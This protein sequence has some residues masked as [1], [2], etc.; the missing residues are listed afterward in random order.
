MATNVAFG[1]SLSAKT[2]PDI[3]AG[4]WDARVGDLVIAEQAA[5]SLVTGRSIRV[6]LPVGAAWHTIPVPNITRGNIAVPTGAIVAGTN[7]RTV[8]YTVTQP[9][10]PSP[11]T[12]EF[13]QGTVNIEADT[14]A[15]NISATVSGTAGASGTVT[16]AKIVAPLAASAEKKNVIIGLGSQ[17]AGD[18][19]IT[20]AGR[21]VLLANPR[22]VGGNLELWCPNGVTFAVTPKVEVT[23]GNLVIDTANVRR[24]GNDTR[25]IIP[26]RTSGTE[27]STIKISGIQLTLDRTVPEG[28]VTLR[29]GGSAVDMVDIPIAGRAAKAATTIAPATTVTPAPV[30]TKVTTVFTVG[31]LSFVRAGVTTPIISAP[32][33]VAGRTLLP[34]RY[35]ALAVGVSADDILWDATRRTVT[36]LRGDRVV[37]L[38]IGDKFMTINGAAIPLSVPAEIR[39]RRI[40]L[41]IR[42]VALALRAQVDWNET[43]RTITVIAQ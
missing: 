16:L 10:V 41:P 35:A 24:M 42:D 3:F 34:L 39:A 37:Q 4:R 11:S 20:E 18:I 13:R 38:R 6:E 36:L 33:I 29:V 26:I 15:A 17:A 19:T 25:L 2:T 28:D 21:G 14:A 8:M 40:M 1:V 31:A 43:A 5:G 12:I 23:K 30:E 22:A 9:A 32:T 27:A 7:R